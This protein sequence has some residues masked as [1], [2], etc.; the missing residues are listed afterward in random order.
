MHN[1]V[2]DFC[3]SEGSPIAEPVFKK[4]LYVCKLK[5]GISVLIPL[6]DVLRGTIVGSGKETN[7]I[8]FRGR[9]S[10]T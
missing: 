5:G 4:D 10:G 9:T 8:Y 7:R 1:N 3:N 2:A 6:K